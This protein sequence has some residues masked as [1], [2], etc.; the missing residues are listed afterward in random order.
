MPSGKLAWE[1]LEPKWLVS[2]RKQLVLEF[3]ATQG[4]E[5]RPFDFQREAGNPDFM[6]NFPIVKSC[7]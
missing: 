7:N 1:R 6:G 2:Y 4:R 3:V 5:P